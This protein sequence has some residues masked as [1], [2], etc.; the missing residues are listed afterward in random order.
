MT[1]AER[2]QY[3]Q[4]IARNMDVAIKCMERS[5]KMLSQLMDKDIENIRS[6]GE[7]FD[8]MIISKSNL[9]DANNIV[10]SKIF[11]G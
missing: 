3:L 1:E 4:D 10:A 6:Y 8:H 11:K 5:Y 9:N 2:Q 7:L